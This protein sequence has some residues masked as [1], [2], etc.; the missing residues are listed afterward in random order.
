MLK[1][2]ESFAQDYLNYFPTHK[3]SNV[4]TES[5]FCPRDLTRKGRKFNMRP[6]ICFLKFVSRLNLWTPLI[7]PP[8]LPILQNK[9]RFSTTLD[10]PMIYPNCEFFRLSKRRTYQIKVYVEMSTLSIGTEPVRTRSEWSGI[11]LYG[12]N[13]ARCGEK[14]PRKLNGDEMGHVPSPSSLRSP[15]FAFFLYLL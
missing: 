11:S 5:L 6:S 9:L 2:V 14:I 4:Q 3:F 13:E 1:W 10:I 7:W 12:G 15:C 8:L